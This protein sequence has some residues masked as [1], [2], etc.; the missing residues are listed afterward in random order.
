VASVVDQRAAIF[1]AL[2]EPVR[3]AI[4]DRLVSG[5]ASPGELAAAVGLGSN[6]LAHHLGVLELAGVIRRVRSEGDHRRSYVQLRAGDPTVWAAA[7]SGR[8]PADLGPVDRVVFVCTANSARS[9]LAAASW[10]HL[11]KVPA[12]SAGTRPATRIHPGAVAVARR[13]GL[14]IE[15]A[16][17]V[18]LHGV[19]RDGDLLVAVCDNVHEQLRSEVPRLH[20]SIPD[21]V[22][23]GTTTAFE[24]AYAEISRRVQHLADLSEETKEAS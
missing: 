22:R 20:W 14:P 9:Q 19:L 6:L 11:S 18:S 21:P 24:D 23:R 16:R 15:G 7:L 4:V 17:P 3:L 5:D 12:T 1:A 10:N 8:L 13:H 2:G